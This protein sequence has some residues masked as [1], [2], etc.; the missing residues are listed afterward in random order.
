MLNRDGHF[1]R[2]CSFSSTSQR[3]VSYRFGLAALSFSEILCSFALQF[4]VTL[5]FILQAMNFD[6]FGKKFVSLFIYFYVY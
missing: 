2:T 6:E 3:H 1:N 5:K 4:G